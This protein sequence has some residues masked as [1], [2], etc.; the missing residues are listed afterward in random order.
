MLSFLQLG[1][2]TIA[3]YSG[4]CKHGGR[5]REQGDRV[6]ERD[7]QHL[8]VHAS[9]EEAALQLGVEAEASDPNV[10]GD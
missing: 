10:Q 1:S 2:L 4:I 5:E 8:R 6:G 7:S 3:M 9:N